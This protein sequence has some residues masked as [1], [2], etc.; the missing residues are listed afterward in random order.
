MRR[1]LVCPIEGEYC[2]LH[3]QAI[4]GRRADGDGG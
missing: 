1:V 3:S 4:E 2:A